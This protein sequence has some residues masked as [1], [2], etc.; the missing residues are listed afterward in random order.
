[1][2]V[3]SSR[4]A[5]TKKDKRDI[6]YMHSIVCTSASPATPRRI[7]WN[8]LMLR[9]RPLRTAPAALRLTEMI[10]V[11]PSF[12]LCYCPMTRSELGSLPSLY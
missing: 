8:C 5:Y 2:S 12:A 4:N 3:S 10:F 6:R 11:F 9:S 1:M 7:S